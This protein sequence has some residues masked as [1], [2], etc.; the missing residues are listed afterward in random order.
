M[1]RTLAIVLACML[2]L[3]A[4]GTTAFGATTDVDTTALKL[5]EDTVTFSFW[6][7]YIQDL[8]LG[9]LADP[10]DG[11]VFGWL[12]KQ[13]NV[14]IDWIIPP[15]SAMS[16]SYTLLFAADRMPDIVYSAKN[17]GYMYAGGPEAAVEDGYFLRLN[18]LMDEYAPNYLAVL[19]GNERVAKDCA[20]DS[21]LRWGFYFIYC[22]ENGKGANYGPCIRQD[23]LDKLGLQIPVTYDDWHTVLTA[24]KDELGIDGALFVDKMGNSRYS[25]WSAGY[26]VGR[27][28]YQ[29]EGVA[30]YGPIEDGYGEY[31]EMMAKWYAEGLV[32]ADFA[33]DS[34]SDSL[35]LPGR[36]AAWCDNA[37]CAG[38][39]YYL[40][41]GAT[42]EDFN[43]VGAPIPVQQVGDVPHLRIKDT[44]VN[45]YI[46]SV[47]TDCAEP[48]LAVRWIDIFYNPEYNNIF[49]YGIRENESYVENE[50]GTLSWG[51][52]IMANTDGLTVTQARMRFTMSNAPLE[53][54]RRVMGSW[55]ETQLFSQKQ[56]LLSPD[57]G[58]ISDKLTMSA[59]EGD[60]QAAIM[61][62]IRLFAEEESAKMIMGTSS[63]TFESFRERINSMNIEE[64]LR[65]EQDALDRYNAR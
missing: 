6:W 45:Q 37:T 2:V 59:D 19:A 11:D 4:A 16:E 5:T 25:E 21:G 3:L 35:R 62:D 14:H 8:Q 28:F 47:S 15:A 42:D 33:L 29:D 26:G 1:K 36:I 48:E 38:S 61:T 43:L 20:T 30:K 22:N 34:D 9:D 41:R 7:P 46:L 49:N 52:L 24:F 32:Y 50:D 63:Y 65:I 44:I 55:N 17:D 13:T 60:R 27:D 23:Y 31:L 56:W 54:Y 51:P 64:A 39:N 18:E 40:T 58:V 12:E 57:D 10:N 53:N